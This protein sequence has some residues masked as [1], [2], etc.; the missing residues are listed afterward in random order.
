MIVPKVNY[1]IYVNG[2]FYKEFTCKPEW[3]G[4]YVDFPIN[5]TPRNVTVITKDVEDAP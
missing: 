5:K 2:R 3:A 1:K 4:F